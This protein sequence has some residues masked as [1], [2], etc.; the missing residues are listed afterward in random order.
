MRIVASVFGSRGDTEPN[1]LLAAEL[2]RRGHDA[3]VVAHPD[4]GYIAEALGVPFYACGDPVRESIRKNARDTGNSIKPGAGGMAAIR[5]EIRSQ[6]AGLAPVVAEGADVILSGGI[7]LSAVSLAEAVGAK[8]QWVLPVPGVIPAADNTPCIL[9]FESLPRP[10][11]AALWKLMD[12]TGGAMAATVNEERAKLGLGKQDGHGGILDGKEM[13]ILHCDPLLGPLA[14]SLR[15][16]VVQTGA[17]LPPAAGALPAE[18]EEFLAAGEPPVFVGFGSMG[19]RDPRA[20]TQLIV[21]AVR[22]AGVRAVI[23]RGWAELAA[24][25]L[26]DDV[27]AI[28]EVAFNLLFPRTA[29]V[30]HHG[31]AGTTAT[32]ARA[33]VPQIVVPQIMDQ[34]YWGNRVWRLGIGTPKLP[35]KKLTAEG[36]AAAIREA[37]GSSAMRERAR[38][39]AEELRGVDGVRLTADE[40]E[41]VAEERAA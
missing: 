25:P 14:P 2:R 37:S 28:D 10:V 4:C 29:A 36:L 8:L 32:A 40:V 5:K 13:P 12:V 6:F 1:I 33:G 34:F 18:V 31:G 35:M 27:L 7:N 9:P 38:V 3:V 20:A 23:A 19:V 41:R 24:G 22:K 30:V 11:N 21:E 15:T 16:R 39:V 26:P 17:I